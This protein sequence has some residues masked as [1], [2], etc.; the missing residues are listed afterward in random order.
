[1]S[2]TYQELSDNVETNLSDIRNTINE[3]ANYVANVSDNVT[4]N[5]NDISSITEKINSGLDKISLNTS[6]ILQLENNIT[7]IQDNVY[8][9]SNLIQKAT[10][11]ISSIYTEIEKQKKLATDAYLELTTNLKAVTSPTYDNIELKGL[12]GGFISSQNKSLYL[13]APDNVSVNGNFEVNGRAIFN[14]NIILNGARNISSDNDITIGAPYIQITGRK[15]S[16]INGKVD[17]TGDVYIP[18]LYSP[19]VCFDENTCLTIDDI[20]KIKALK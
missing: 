20:K 2:T 16:K 8:G 6:N 3:E 7:S 12:N 18:S 5:M 1:M 17:F 13:S 10:N 15:G 11:Q 19:E 14:N 4:T 9:N